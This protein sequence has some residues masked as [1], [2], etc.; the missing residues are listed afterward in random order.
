VSKSAPLTLEMA[1]Q[2]AH[3]LGFKLGDTLTSKFWDGVPLR[4]ERFEGAQV[5]VTRLHEV[6]PG[7]WRDGA[8]HMMRYLPADVTIKQTVRGRFVP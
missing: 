8:S 7:D 5:W 6:A 3:R 4:L 1:T 2:T